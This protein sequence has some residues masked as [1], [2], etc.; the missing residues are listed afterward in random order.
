MARKPGLVT[1]IDKWVNVLKIHCPHHESEH[2]LNIAF[3]P[4]CG[5]RAL[6]E[7]ALRRNDAAFLNALRSAS[8]R[9]PTQGDH[10]PWL[11]PFGR[12]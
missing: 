6:D 9:R 4:M 11:A 12:S 2:V 10:A 1:A 7:I 3:N 5:G 8:R